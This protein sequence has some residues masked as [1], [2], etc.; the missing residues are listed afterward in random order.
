MSPANPALSFDLL[1][2]LQQLLA[3]HFM[4]NAY[5]A[6]ALV[7]VLSGVIGYFVVLRGQT[8]AAHTLSQV[9]FPGASGATV[10]GV[11]P[12]A[13]LGLICAGS[14]LGIAGLGRSAGRSRTIEAAAIGSIQA[15]ALAL[16]YMFA[17]L[18]SG[19]INGVTDVL[20]GTFL[21]ITDEQV[22]ELAVITVAGLG[23]MAVIGRPLFF[24]SLDVELAAARRVPVRTLSL[25]FIVFLGLA[26]AS[27]TLITGA[28]L[29]FCLLVA[30]AAAAQLLT[31]RPW[32]GVVLAAVLGVAVVWLALALAYFSPFPI[33]F[34]VTSLGFGLY[35]AAWGVRWLER[36]KS[37]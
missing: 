7:A 32:H 25:L 28:L 12:L 31:S 15:F 9:G 4:Q 13:G 33:G 10:A 8:F 16:G 29:V 11:N 35:L 24:L 3:F 1:A 30:P 18:Y 5:A 23:L 17:S 19:S 27:V 22:V 2:D 36:R 37:R 34:F 21:G 20:F 6:G 14:A 26:V